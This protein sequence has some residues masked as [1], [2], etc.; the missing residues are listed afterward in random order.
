M[1]VIKTKSPLL[2]VNGVGTISFNPKERRY[3]DSDSIDYD[4][5]QN[6]TYGT[7]LGLIWVNLVHKPQT[8]N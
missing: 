2:P 3:Y 4:L 6:L 8:Q 7:K 5:A 1:K